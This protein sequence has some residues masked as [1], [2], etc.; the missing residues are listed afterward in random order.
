VERSEKK[1]KEVERSS[2]QFPCTLNRTKATGKTYKQ[3]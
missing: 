2:I 3:H 1:W